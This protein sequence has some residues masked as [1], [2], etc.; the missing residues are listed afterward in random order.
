MGDQLKITREKQH[1]TITQ[2]RHNIHIP[3]PLEGTSTK[4]LKDILASVPDTATLS[5]LHQESWGVV[6]SFEEHADLRL[7]EHAI[8]KKS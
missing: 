5:Y 3:F 7:I 4:Q 6:M 1:A 8:E 2:A